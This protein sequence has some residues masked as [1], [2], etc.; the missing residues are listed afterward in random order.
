METDDDASPRDPS[1]SDGPWMSR[2]GQYLEVSGDIVHAKV[3]DAL[4]VFVK[5][6]EIESHIE[7]MIRQFVNS[8]PGYE[9]QNGV[10]FVFP[11]DTIVPLP[12]G[13]S[14]NRIYLPDREVRMVKFLNFS[15]SLRT[16]KSTA[17]TGHS[18][19]LV[20]ISGLKPTNLDSPDALIRGMEYANDVLAAYSLVRHDHG[21]QRLTLGTLPSRIRTIEIDEDDG[22]SFR[23]IGVVVPNGQDIADRISK[24]LLIDDDELELFRR[25]CE[26]LP[27]RPAARYLADLMQTSIKKLCLQDH[28][29]AILDS[30]RFAELAIR[31]VA[32]QIT[33][34]TP[35]ETIENQNLFTRGK[36]SN[37]GVLNHVARELRFTG[38]HKISLWTK[39]ARG[40]RNKLMHGL[41]FSTIT[42]QQAHTAAKADLELVQLAVSKLPE[43]AWDIKVLGTGAETYHRLFSHG[44]RIPRA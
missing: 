21:I 24:R 35:A 42:S 5:D 33:T 6:L 18:I 11:Y 16:E 28:D 37:A 44:K 13:Y 10:A 20:C 25:Y 43:A 23:D 4:T 32:S 29:G 7:N 19:A 31:L 8:E 40:L 38:S 34:L 9:I 41:E 17:R 14:S 15:T 3:L 22:L 26:E 36:N 27:F 30:G 39:N 2:Y 12:P 1:L